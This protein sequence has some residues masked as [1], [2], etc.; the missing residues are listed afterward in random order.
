[1]LPFTSSFL[2][3]FLHLDQYRNIPLNPPLINPGSRPGS[4]STH[5]HRQKCSATTSSSSSPCAT[6]TP[7][8]SDSQPGNGPPGRN[9]FSPARIW[10]CGCG[11][12]RRKTKTAKTNSRCASKPA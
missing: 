2:S 12:W 5:L 6:S 4:G 3:F 9:G 11:P 7:S 10:R 8:S 1:R